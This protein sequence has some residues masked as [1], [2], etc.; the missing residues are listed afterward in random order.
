MAEAQQLFE[1]QLLVDG[2]GAVERAAVG[3]LHTAD[4]LAQVLLERMVRQVAEIVEAHVGGDLEF[5]H[6][7]L[8][9]QLPDQLPAA[10]RLQIA[11]IQPV[12]DAHVR[13]RLPG[14]ERFAHT[15]DAVG[16]VVA[17]AVVFAGMDA[18]HKAR[19]FAG[20]GHQ[21]PDHAAHFQDVID[22]LSDDVAAGHEGIGCHGAQHLQVFGQIAAGRHTVAHDGQRRA[23]DGREEAQQHARLP[24]NFGHH[25][26]DLAQNLRRL[27]LLAKT[28]VGDLGV[29]DAVTA[30]AAGDPEELVLEKRVVPVVF[31]LAVPEH[32]PEH[33]AD[34]RVR[35]TLPALQRDR[36]I[37]RLALG[38]HIAVEIDLFQIGK[39]GLPVLRDGQGDAD[40]G[41]VLRRVRRISQDQVRK[42][43]EGIV[44]D[45]AFEIFPGQRRIV[46]RLSGRR[47]RPLQLRLLR[48]AAAQPQLFDVVQRIADLVA[49]AERDQHI[50]LEVAAHVGVQIGAELA[51]A[52]NIGLDDGFRHAQAVVLGLAHQSLG[53]GRDA[54]LH[55]HAA[56]R[57]DV[58]DL[59]VA[60]AEDV[61]LPVVAV[62]VAGH[63]AADDLQSLVVK[64]Q[65]QLTEPGQIGDE[66][67]G[68]VIGRA[69]DILEFIALAVELDDDIL[70]LVEIKA[71]ERRHGLPPPRMILTIVSSA[72]GKCN[73]E[74]KKH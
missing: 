6:D 15:A 38:E 69:Q 22:L 46:Q 10:R 28:R 7:P 54:G 43:E 52:E 23:A 67:A 27:L 25:F 44:V 17:Q 66:V 72:P 51:V 21:L 45:A 68:A 36:V 32:L 16:D 13:H 37:R 48:L 53:D 26:V 29:V 71:S 35:Q 9:P 74:A 12:A 65:R 11:G 55:F 61:E 30:V 58:G 2:V 1:A 60:H 39:D 64:G 57:E 49:D 63:A 41:D 47:P 18:Q 56:V 42:V 40:A 50:R 19:R 31:A 14:R 3:A 20:N 33:R 62:D 73:R 34:L 24:R 5:Q 70:F 59:G 8:L 4:A